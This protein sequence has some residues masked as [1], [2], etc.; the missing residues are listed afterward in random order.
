MRLIYCSPRGQLLYVY[1]CWPES[2][3]TIHLTVA[4][5][6]G[7]TERQLALQEAVAENEDLAVI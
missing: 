1:V 4:H 7:K 6:A 5:S 2:G 3:R